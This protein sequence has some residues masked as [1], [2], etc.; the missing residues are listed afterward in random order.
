MG[1]KHKGKRVD[2]NDIDDRLQVNY[3]GDKIMIAW[4]S[5]DDTHTSVVIPEKAVSYLVRK[6]AS[7]M[8]L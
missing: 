7:W 3:V 6:L 8:E 5:K 4:L 2:V 1:K